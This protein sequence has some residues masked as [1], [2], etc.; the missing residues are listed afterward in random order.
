MKLTEANKNL[1]NLNS[2]TKT[3]KS[4]TSTLKKDREYEHNK[5]L[6]YLFENIII[7]PM[8]TLYT[9]LSSNLKTIGQQKTEKIKLM[10]GNYSSCC[11]QR[12]LQQ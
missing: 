7:H 5:E 3:G 1:I 2:F 8:D 12:S 4:P 10:R 9:F 6:L 11:I